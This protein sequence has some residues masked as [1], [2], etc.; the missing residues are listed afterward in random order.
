MSIVQP[1]YF[2]SD[3]HLGIP[4][5]AASLEREKHIVKWLHTIAPDSG[6]LFLLGDLFDFW[7]EY[8]RVV[9]KG[10]VRLLGALAEM[11]DSGIP[12]HIFTGNHDMWMRGY[13]ADELGATVFKGPKDFTLHGKRFLLG[14]GDGLGPGDKGYKRLK[15]VFSNR[16]AQWLFAR[17]HPNFAIWLANY[18]SQ[19]S[20]LMDGG[21]IPDYLGDDKE[22]LF[23]YC[24]QR[25]EQE[26][27]DYFIFGHRHIP[28]D[29]EVR[30]GSRYLNL[31][32]WIHH[33]TYAVFD[34][35]NVVMKSE[36]PR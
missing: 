3:F 19:H 1:I 31:G 35:Q 17:L 11:A 14:H 29:R 13:L 2:A 5:H 22:W 9:P 15:R 33:Y 18:W 10:Y 20:R 4:N 26:H 27:F 28:I 25:L 30:P 21:H 34:G 23:Q 12:V 36:K 16:T 32:D 6:G 24:L 7:F 8:K